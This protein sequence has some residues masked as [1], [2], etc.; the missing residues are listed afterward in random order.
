MGITVGSVLHTVAL[1]VREI[2]AGRMP[3]TNQYEFATSFAWGICL[4]F[5]I[6]E[7][8]YHF[9]ALGTFVTPVIFLI[10]GYAAGGTAGFDQLPGC[11]AGISVPFLCYCQR[12]HLGRT[13]LGQLL[14]LGFQGDLVSDY[15]D[16]LCP[17][18]AFETLQRMA[19][20]AGRGI[21]RGG[22]CVCCSPTGKKLSK[23][24]SV[25]LQYM[26]DSEERK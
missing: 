2:E 7:K 5:L 9:Q 1:V 15:M 21:C 11:I 23:K 22:I 24:R 3:L 14:V 4:C 10:I 19:R 26:L 6:F 20:Q 8:K 25:G 13:D 16:H 17:V 12:G 18:P